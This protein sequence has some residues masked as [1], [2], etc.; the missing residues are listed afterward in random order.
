MALTVVGTQSDPL[1]SVVRVAVGIARVAV[2]A[3]MA[4]MF[5]SFTSFLTTLF[6]FFGASAG[7][8]S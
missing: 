6:T 7:L 4:A 2:A 5:S 8:H 3:T 1:R